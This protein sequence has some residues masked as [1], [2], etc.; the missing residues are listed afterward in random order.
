MFVYSIK[1]SVQVIQCSYIGGE[2]KVERKERKKNSSVPVGLEPTTSCFRG[3]CTTTVLWE[4][5]RAVMSFYPTWESLRLLSGREQICERIS[6]CTA[7]ILQW[8]ALRLIIPCISLPISRPVEWKN[9]E[10]CIGQK[11]RKKGIRKERKKNS[12]LPVGL[13][14][15]SYLLLPR[16]VHYQCGRAT[17]GI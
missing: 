14:P 2:K 1:S 7:S 6:A 17:D 9:G 11:E 12:A 4:S 8:I 3:K 13:E 5:Y 15:T 10:E 16:Q